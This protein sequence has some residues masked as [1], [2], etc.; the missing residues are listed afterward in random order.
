V[1]WQCKSRASATWQQHVPPQ[2]QAKAFHDPLPV[3]VQA[4]A[5]ATPRGCGLLLLRLGAPVVVNIDFNNIKCRLLIFPVIN[6]HSVTAAGCQE[7][8]A[9]A[10]A[11]PAA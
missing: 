2:H 8:E 4:A 5:T 9:G 1:A 10:A 7:R 3:N 11:P 6:L